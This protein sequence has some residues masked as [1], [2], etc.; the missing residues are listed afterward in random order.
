M[1]RTIHIG[2]ISIPK[3]SISFRSFSGFRLPSNNPFVGY[4]TSRES[5]TQEMG[6]SSRISKLHQE[7]TLF[8][9]VHQ[10]GINRRVKELLRSLPF[11]PFMN[12]N[13]LQCFYVLYG[14]KIN[15][16]QLQIHETVR[17]HL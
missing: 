4:S 7:Y 8:H 5:W 10:L 11:E 6:T 14:L 1:V 15:I 3:I 9:T 16:K 17:K 12:N 13:V 2:F